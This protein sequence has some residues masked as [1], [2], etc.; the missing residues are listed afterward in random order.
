MLKINKPLIVLKR[1]AHNFESGINSLTRQINSMGKKILIVGKN[2]IGYEK[3][4]WNKSFTFRQKDQFNLLI[5]DNQTNQ[6][7][8]SNDI[9]KARLAKLAWGNNLV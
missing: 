4:E 8:N 1:D 3:N 2:G 7:I 9:E 5:S 6:Y